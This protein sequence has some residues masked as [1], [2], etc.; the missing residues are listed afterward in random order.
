[1][2]RRN[3]MKRRGA[4]HWIAA[5]AS[6]AMLAGTGCAGMRATPKPA[7]VFSLVT[8]NLYHDKANWPARR[9]LIIDGLRRLNPSAIVLQEVLQHGS[10]RNQAEDL[11]E[12]LGYRAYFISIDPPGN[13]RRYGNAIL[14]RH[15]VLARDWT[16]LR[17]LGDSRTAGMVRIEVDGHPL[18]IYV[19]HP[20]Y[21]DNADGTRMRMQQLG[22]LADFISRTAGEAPSIIAGDFNTASGTP[23]LARIEAGFDDAYDVL[24]GRNDAPPTLNPHYFPDDRRRIDHAYLQRGRIIALEARNVLDHADAAGHW[25]SDHFGVYVR[26][27]FAPLH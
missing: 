24:H 12:A 9:A 1:M 4:L 13:A 25:P 11:A 3:D 8:F 16:K 22:D 23:E 15:P 14:T 20:N 19:T 18:N 17:P 26:V 27:A 5:T 21:Q 2:S 7:P 6:M 10:L